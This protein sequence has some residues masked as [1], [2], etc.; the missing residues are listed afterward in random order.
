MKTHKV[1]D[2]IISRTHIECIDTGTENNPLVVKIVWYNHGCHRRIIA[3][4]QDIASVL[5]FLLDFANA[6]LGWETPETKIAWAK[7]YAKGG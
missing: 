1:L 7:N 5:C 6:H 2:T 4:Y 3:K